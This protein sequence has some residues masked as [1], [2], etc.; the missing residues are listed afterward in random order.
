MKPTVEY[1]AKD[2]STIM[3][4]NFE[5]TYHLCQLAHPYL[6]ASGAA[7]I[8][9]I[10]SVAGVVSIK[11]VS[12]VYGATKGILHLTHTHTHTHIYI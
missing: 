2:F 3:S 1:T 6:K 11:G 5:S 8:V 9:F 12:A 4:T 10:S 7:S